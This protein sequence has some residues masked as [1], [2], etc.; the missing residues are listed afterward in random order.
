MS[1]VVPVTRTRRQIVAEEARELSVLV[2]SLER[3]R[4]DNVKFR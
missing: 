4:Y 1:D 3:L 2:H